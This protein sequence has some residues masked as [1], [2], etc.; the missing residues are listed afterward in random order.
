M[1][2]KEQ[3]D[4]LDMVARRDGAYETIQTERGLI[5]RAVGGAEILRDEVAEPPSEIEQL[6]AR[7]VALESRT[8]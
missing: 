8:R 1:L 7:I 3:Q 4:L 5:Y 6:K 2:T